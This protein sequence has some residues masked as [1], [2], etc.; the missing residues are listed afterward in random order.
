MPQR[1]GNKRSSQTPPSLS[2]H[3]ETLVKSSLRVGCFRRNCT[4]PMNPFGLSK[5]FRAYRDA[6]SKSLR[7]PASTR[8]SP[9]ARRPSTTRPDEAL[10]RFAQDDRCL[11]NSIDACVKVRQGVR[12]AS[13]MTYQASLRNKKTL[14]ISRSAGVGV[15]HGAVAA[16]ETCRSR[17]V[18]RCGHIR[19]RSAGGQAYWDRGN[20]PDRPRL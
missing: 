12:Y 18:D 5:A 20:T 15:L 4:P 13:N 9:F 19:Y 16:I 3:G 17:R 11:V 10:G 8:P 1:L 14:P 6:S 7:H 2:L